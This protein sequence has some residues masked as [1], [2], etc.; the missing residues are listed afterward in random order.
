M[1][2]INRKT[3]SIQLHHSSSSDYSILNELLSDKLGFTEYYKYFS[4]YSEKTIFLQDL[5]IETYV[6]RIFKTYSRAL[7]LLHMQ[8]QSFSYWHCFLNSHFI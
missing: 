3:A 2:N 8:L 4:K 6:G 1:I 5:A 7:K